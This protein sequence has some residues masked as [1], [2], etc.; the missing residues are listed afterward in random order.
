[1][2]IETYI[3]NAFTNK[4][5][6]GNPAGVCIVDS[7]INEKVMQKIAAQLNLSETAFLIKNT[8]GEDYL[9]RYF[10]P[11]V[12]IDFCG[13]AT[14]ASAKLVIDRL[15]K[16]AVNFITGKGLKIL[17]NKQDN[18]IRM[19]FPLY[20]TV[21][22]N[23]NKNLISAFGIEEFSSFQFCEELDMLLIEVLD[24]QTLLNISPDFQKAIESS[25]KIKE[26]VITTKSEDDNY[27]FY[28][29][30]FCP[31]IGI[32]EDPVTGASHSVLAK[33]WS[34]KLSK[35]ELSAYQLS[36]RGGFLNL[37]I[38]GEEKLEVL[39]EAQIV[40]EGQINI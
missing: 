5:F 1:M 18:F 29:R 32:N 35:S 3:I 39:S 31:W 23:V 15:N 9:I 16:K 11:I 10:T 38:L 17:A 26:V 2:Q 24:K 8:D 28:S 21:D 6:S 33:Y 7:T 37:K 13:H 36:K 19:E 25:K 27:D 20:Q 34:N 14:L 22:Y 4:A 30:C 40:L 12:E